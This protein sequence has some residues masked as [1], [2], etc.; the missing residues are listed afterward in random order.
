MMPAMWESIRRKR[1]TRRPQ[2]L[3][4]G[5]SGVKNRKTRNLRAL[6][7]V[8]HIPE[9]RKIGCE[10]YFWGP[11]RELPKSRVGTDLTSEGY[12]TWVFVPRQVPE[13][14]KL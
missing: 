5:G 14:C 10:V 13:W 9:L 6:R 1:R 12:L 11:Q 4:R 2:D 7:Q 3:G 8:L